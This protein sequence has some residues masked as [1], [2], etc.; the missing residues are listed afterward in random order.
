MARLGACLGFVA[1]VPFLSLLIC[2]TGLGDNERRADF[3]GPFSHRV[4]AKGA[5]ISTSRSFSRLEC[6]LAC[7]LNAACLS[8]I[9]GAAEEMCQLNSK[10][11]DE[12]GDNTGYRYYE[13]P[14]SRSTAGK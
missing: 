10:R 6:G 7:S 3:N 14:R 2:S 8:F 9:Y 13:R 5:I 11:S 4:V 1:L 12:E